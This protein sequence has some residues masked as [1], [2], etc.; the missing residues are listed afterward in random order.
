[1]PRLVMRRVSRFR[2]SGPATQSICQLGNVAQS[3]ESGLVGLFRFLPLTKSLRV[4]IQQVGR[5]FF[6][7][8]ADFLRVRQPLKCLVDVFAQFFLGVTV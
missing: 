6:P 1:M 8:I 7:G 4:I 2:R 3:A 5:K